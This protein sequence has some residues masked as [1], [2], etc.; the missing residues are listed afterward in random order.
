MNLDYFILILIIII[1]TTKLFKF[2]RKDNYPVRLN[3]LFKKLHQSYFPTLQITLLILY[4]ELKESS[5]SCKEPSILYSLIIQDFF[6]PTVNNSDFSKGNHLNIEICLSFDS[7]FNKNPLTSCKGLK[8]S[9]KSDF[10]TRK[11][12]L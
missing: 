5:Y 3:L 6:F 9:L 4:K 12:A 2:G 7:L 10:L 1:Q 11:Y 8:F